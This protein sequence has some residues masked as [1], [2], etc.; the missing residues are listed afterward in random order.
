MHNKTGTL[1]TNQRARMLLVQP[2]STSYN[3]IVDKFQSPMKGILK[4]WHTNK[5]CTLK[6]KHF[7][8][9]INYNYVNTDTTFIYV[10]HWLHRHCINANRAINI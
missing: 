2:Y 4:K 1:Y 3:S 6:E 5:K 7:L 8:S 9:K 10:S